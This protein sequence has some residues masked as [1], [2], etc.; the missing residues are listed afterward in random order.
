MVDFSIIFIL[1]GPR[2]E[3]SLS[4]VRSGESGGPEDFNAAMRQSVSVGAERD[5]A[6][7]P[8]KVKGIVD[9]GIGP[10]TG[11]IVPNFFSY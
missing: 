7:P 10:P 1:W 2:C 11:S 3:P 9:T 5:Y 8:G 4:A 6:S